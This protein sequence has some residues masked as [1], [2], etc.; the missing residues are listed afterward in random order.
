MWKFRSP[1]RG[2]GSLGNR[3]PT[4]RQGIGSGTDPNR[5][6]NG[7]RARSKERTLRSNFPHAIP[8]LSPEGGSPS[9]SCASAV[10]ARETRPSSTVGDRIFPLTHRRPI[11]MWRGLAYPTPTEQLA[12]YRGHLASLRRRARKRFLKATNQD[13]RVEG[14]GK[15]VDRPRCQHVGSGRLA[16]VPGHEHYRDSMPV[17]D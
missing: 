10:D 13:S 12:G 7:L 9:Y 15:I 11:G 6:E 14:L 4:L 8:L 16:E 1:N 5:N 17:G 2:V 3:S